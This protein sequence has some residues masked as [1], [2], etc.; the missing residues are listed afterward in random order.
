METSSLPD[1][2]PDDLFVLDVREDD[3]WAAGHVE[4]SVHIPMM[5][6]PQRLHELPHDRQVLVVC[7]VGSRSARVT[8]FLQAQ[9]IDAANLAGGLVAWDWARRPMVADHDGQPF[10]G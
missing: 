3:E 1:P 5:L 6:V 2:L 10:V 9:G 4:G 8:V 7:K